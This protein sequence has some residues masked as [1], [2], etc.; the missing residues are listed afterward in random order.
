MYDRERTHLAAC[1]QE[2]SSMARRKISGA[3]RQRAMSIDEFCEHYR[4]GR[5]T[6]YEEIKRGRLRA[7][8][9]GR[10]TIIGDDDG[11]DWFRRLPMIGSSP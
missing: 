1:V 2:R 10:R 5:T 4:V 3:G 7:R 8:K 11:E 6:A 9:C